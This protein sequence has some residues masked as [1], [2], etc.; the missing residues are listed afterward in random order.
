MPCC[1]HDTHAEHCWQPAGSIFFS[2]SSIAG[3]FLCV[4]NH[5]I[6]NKFLVAY[7]YAFGSTLYTWGAYCSV[8]ASQQLL[9]SISS[10]PVALVAANH[11]GANQQ[12]QSMARRPRLL[13]LMS[14]ESASIMKAQTL[15]PSTWQRMLVPMRLRGWTEAMSP[16]TAWATVNL[17][18][19]LFVWLAC[20]PE[21]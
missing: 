10:S 8:L 21:F 2:F 17:A 13:G 9:K 7:P 15:Q 6:R 18:G 14:F 11:K 4:A 3:L 20:S 16:D 1:C 5:G 12:N 19:R